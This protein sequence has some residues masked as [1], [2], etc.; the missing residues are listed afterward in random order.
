[1]KNEQTIRRLN[2]LYRKA[3]RD[4]EMNIENYIENG[5]K[6]VVFDS[7]TRATINKRFP[8][9]EVYLPTGIIKGQKFLIDD[10]LKESNAFS[11]CNRG[12]IDIKYESFTY[13][14]IFREK[15]IRKDDLGLEIKLDEISYDL[16]KEVPKLYI[17]GEEVGVV[18][19]TRHYITTNVELATNVAT[20]V[21][22]DKSSEKQKILSIDLV[23]EE[24]FHQS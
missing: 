3:K 11:F 14:F 2:K 10:R 17:K 22:L 1:M 7:I 8:H 20:F 13:A 24:I 5:F 16:N 6:I 12:K 19:M 23:N 15:E 21:Y 9:L 18:S 4:L